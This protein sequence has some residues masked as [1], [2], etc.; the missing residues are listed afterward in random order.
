MGSETDFLFLIRNMIANNEAEKAYVT[1]KTFTRC[2]KTVE[3]LVQFFEEVGMREIAIK[4]ETHFEEKTKQL[5]YEAMQQHRLDEL[6]KE[7]HRNLSVKPLNPM[8]RAV[9]PMSQT[10]SSI[11]RVSTS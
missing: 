2:A 5:E 10:S 1:V 6:Q 9:N 11:S 4:I 8:Q 7:I 3:K